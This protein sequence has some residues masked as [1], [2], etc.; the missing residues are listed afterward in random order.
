MREPWE[1]DDEREDLWAE[2][3]ELAARLA[4]IEVGMF[5]QNQV[6]SGEFENFPCLRSLGE[7]STIDFDYDFED[8]D[9][10]DVPTTPTRL[11]K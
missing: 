4:A 8:G 2:S 11:A 5:W 6:E 3:P 10:F 7:T 9:D 1:V